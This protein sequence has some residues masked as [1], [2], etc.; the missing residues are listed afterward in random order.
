MKKIPIYESVCL[1][2]LASPSLA[3]VGLWALWHGAALTEML[4]LTALPAAVRWGF[5]CLERNSLKLLK[6]LHKLWCNLSCF[7]MLFCRISA[8]LPALNDNLKN[9]RALNCSE[10]WVHRAAQHTLS[11]SAAKGR[12]A[13]MAL[14]SLKHSF[15]AVS[16][17]PDAGCLWP[18]S[19]CSVPQQTKS[20]CPCETL[21]GFWRKSCGCSGERVC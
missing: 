11:L 4:W 10:V 1:R 5:V 16:E 19:S 13:G 12:A 7:G 2:H 6:L 20:R 3:L 14:C 15:Q 21:A 18:T 9:N 17:S 8:E